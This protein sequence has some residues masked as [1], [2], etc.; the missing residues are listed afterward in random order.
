VMLEVG[1]IL[2]VYDFQFKNG[3]PDRNKYFIILNIVDDDLFVA[4]LPTKHDH[5]P[6]QIEKNHGCLNDDSLRFN[7]YYFPKDH[8]ITED[9]GFG[10]PLNTYVY[11]EEVDSYS[12]EKFHDTYTEFV[13]YELVG[14][15]KEDEFQGLIDCLKRSGQTK[16]RIKRLL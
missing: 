15:M 14:K 9:T 1:N 13:D 11:G 3:N 12:V 10:F 7:C 4:S 16:R 5:V 8:V 6:Q 2:Y